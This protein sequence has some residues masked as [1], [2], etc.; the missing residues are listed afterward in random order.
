MTLAGTSVGRRFAAIAI[1]IVCLVAAAVA[2]TPPQ[3]QSAKPQ[4]RVDP[5]TGLPPGTPDF[6]GVWTN[7]WIVNMADGR[8]VE[9]TVEV[10]LNDKGRAL[11]AERTGNLQK[12][13]P[14]MTCKPSGLPRQGGTP[15]PL[16]IM[17]TADEFV[18]LYEGG[19]HTFRIIP[20]DGR[21]HK[22]DP[23]SWYGDSIGRWEG[24]TLVVDTIGFNDKSWLDSS[25]YPH[26]EK[27]HLVERFRRTDPNTMR[28]EVTIDDP[29]YYTRPWTTAWTYRYSPTVELMEYFCTENERDREHMVGK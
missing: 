4:V 12:D 19:M 18:I 9:K 3:A 17:Q 10:P 15:Y 27:L 20:L 24:D 5:D 2:Q 29:E 8:Y 13:D 28:Y 6:R 25:G 23:W 26:G 7:R 11:Y 22:A 21:P 16:K 1:A 14:N